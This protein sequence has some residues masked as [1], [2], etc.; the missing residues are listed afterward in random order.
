GL[1]GEIERAL[2]L[3]GEGRGGPTAQRDGERAG[4][5]R[6]RLGGGEPR[7]DVALGETMAGIVARGGN[8]PHPTLPRKGGG[9]SWKAMVFPPFPRRGRVG[10]GVFGRTGTRGRRRRSSTAHFL[11][12][13]R[14]LVRRTRGGNLGPRRDLRHGDVPPG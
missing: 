11:A 7:G 10:V 12:F 5:A 9:D 6:Q 8:T 4:L 1:G 2:A 3:D 14:R 13:L